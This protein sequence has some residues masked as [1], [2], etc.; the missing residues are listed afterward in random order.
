MKDLIVR[1]Q[2]GDQEAFCELMQMQQQLLYKIARTRLENTADIADAIQ[3]TMISAYQNI[4]GLRHVKYF[5][6]WLVRILINSCNA[7]Y[8]E[9][10]PAISLDALENEP[11]IM[12]EK[13][14]HQ[15]E[16]KLDFESAMQ[17]LPF[18]ERQ[19]LTLFYMQEFSIKEIGKLMD[20]NT[21]TVKTKLRRGKERLREQ[22]KEGYPCINI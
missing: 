10:I 7:I 1:A 3:S 13:S 18:E 16:L 2:Q 5:E 22:M 19:V 20:L 9:K 15:T 8:R 6:T 11:L 4:A 12:A 21:N 17:I 14:N